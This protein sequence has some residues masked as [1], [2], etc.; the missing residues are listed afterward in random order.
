MS[1]RSRAAPTSTAPPVAAK[2]SVPSR[3]REG[4]PE[5]APGEIEKLRVDHVLLTVRSG[6]LGEGTLSVTTA[7]LLWTS[8]ART[9]EVQW[10]DI[11][12]HAASLGP[13]PHL[14]M[15]LSADD[16]DDEEEEGD[17]GGE[18]GADDVRITPPLSVAVDVVFAAMTSCAEL[19]PDLGDPISLGLGGEGGMSAEDVAAAEAEWVSKFKG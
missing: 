3:L 4:V 17:E 1:K 19:H 14:F 11:V 6:S 13:P 15:Q 16:D 5:L 7:R 18:L 12:L 8:P 2:T 10:R 9:V